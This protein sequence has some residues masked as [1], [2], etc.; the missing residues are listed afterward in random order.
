MFWFNC[1]YPLANLCKLK[2]TKEIWR[3]WKAFANMQP[4]GYVYYTYIIVYS[5]H[6]SYLLKQTTKITKKMLTF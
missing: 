6:I 5:K 3:K 2:Q 4:N 1:N